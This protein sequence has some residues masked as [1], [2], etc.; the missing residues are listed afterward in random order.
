MII[1]H[2]GKPV[3]KRTRAAFLVGSAVLLWVASLRVERSAVQGPEEA[4]FRSINDLTPVL[5]PPVWVVM[6]LGSFAAIPVVAIVAAALRRFRLAAE[7]LVAGWGAYLLADLVKEAIRRPRPAA[8][9]AEVTLREPVAGLG[10]VSGHAAVAAAL[11]TVAWP[12][13]GKRG[14]ILSAIAVG[15]V[16]FGRVYSGAHFPL[17]VLG[18]AALGIATGCLVLLVGEVLLPLSRPSQD[19]R[20][21]EKKAA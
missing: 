13:L 3:R 5:W 14:R 20:R 4:L 18:G 9:I 17:D 15:V 10:F 12:H 8:L 7:L 11:A 6:Q 21:V 1:A 2:A 19:K 16:G